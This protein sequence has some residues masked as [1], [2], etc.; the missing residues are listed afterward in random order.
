MRTVIKTY[1]FKLYKSKKNKHLNHSIDIG[2]SIWNYCIAMHRRYY[3]LYKKH[4]SANKLMKHITKIKKTLHP[5]WKD[6]GSQAIQDVVQRVERSYKAFFEHHKQKRHGKKS[7]PSFKKRSRYTSFTLKQS[8]YA[9]GPGN[10][11]TIMGRDYKY[12]KSRPIDG[13]IKT[14]T[15][16]RNLMGEIFLFVV[17]KQECN[18]VYSRT[19][20]AVGMDFGLK[21]FLTLDNEEKIDSPEWYKSSLKELR[22]A[23][24]AVSRCQKGSRNRQRALLHLERVYE[25][26]SNQRRDWFFKMAYHLAGEYAF[27]CIEDL[28]VDAMKKHWGRKVSDLA[29]SEFYS[30]LDWVAS[31]TGSTVIKV[32]KWY[33]S[34]KTCHVCGIVNPNLKLDQRTWVCD[35]CHSKLDRDV[36]AAINI[37]R[38][39]L[40][41]MS[42]AL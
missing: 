10:K 33:P 13:T 16:K 24:K 23:H 12:S 3:R 35:T 7:P 19:G 9:F 14:L 26:V 29:V 37:K 11:V 20:N 34:S 4:L 42:I 39:G 41:T 32:D 38:E 25:K 8:G 5:E 40:A 30:I 17:V 28:N 36:N 15:V 31:N 22:T 1:K 27:I 6:L 18:E 2:A 21:H